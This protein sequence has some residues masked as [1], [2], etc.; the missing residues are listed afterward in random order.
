MCLETITDGAPRFVVH[1]IAIT[2]IQFNETFVFS[3]SVRNCKETSFTIL[4]AVGNERS[5]DFQTTV[6]AQT[7]RENGIVNVTNIN[8]GRALIASKTLCQKSLPQRS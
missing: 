1:T 4:R 8:P 2:K 7:I 5:E 3:Y 6:S